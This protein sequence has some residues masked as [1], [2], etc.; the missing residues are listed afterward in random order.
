M[1]VKENRSLELSNIAK[2]LLQQDL[3]GLFYDMFPFEKLSKLKRDKSRDRVF[4]TENTILTMILTMVERDKSLQT[5]VNIYSIIHDRN[6]DRIANLESEELQ[7]IEQNKS[8]KK[9]GRPRVIA[10]KIQKSKKQSISRD[11]SGFSQA[12]QRLLKAAVDLVYQESKE[13]SGIKYANLWHNRR[14]FITDGTYLQMQDTKEIKEQFQAS[15]TGNYPRGLLQVLIEQGSGSIYDFQLG[16]DKLSE[17]ILFAKMLLNLPSGSLIL[18]DDYYNSFALFK[19]LEEKKI[20]IIVPGKR[21]RIYNVIK[22]LGNGD[23]IVEIKNTKS[24][25]LSTAYNI[26]ASNMLMRRISYK[27]SNDAEKELVLYTSLLDEKITKEEIILKYEQRW[28]IEISIREIKTMFD[29]NVIR[30]KTPEM[31]YKE[32]ATSIIAYNY[33]RRIIAIAAEKSGFPPQ[34][35]IFQKFYENN[36]RAYVDKLG[37]KYSKPSPGRGGYSSPNAIK[38]HNS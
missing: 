12:R 9:V 32:L 21:K 8:E 33:V 4:N 10:S 30:A 6:Q 7:K 14:V 5:S 29:I 26:T 18:A 35:N 3:S 11:T 31:A 25:M 19:L 23:E 17:L 24:S 37:R 36:S 16:S 1:I 34:E 28:D 27:S 20:D 2:D 38:T 22:S 13:F 15:K